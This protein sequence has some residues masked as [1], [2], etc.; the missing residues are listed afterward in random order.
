MIGE[1]RMQ[2]ETLPTYLELWDAKQREMF[3]ESISCYLHNE[4][5]ALQGNH[6]LHDVSW[7]AKVMYSRRNGAAMN[8]LDR[9]GDETKK[10]YLELAETAIICLPEL[11]DRI[12]SRYITAKA[13]IETELNRARA[14]VAAKEKRMSKIRKDS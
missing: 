7:L 1:T 4:G 2:A 12:G 5:Y 10:E 6:P 3:L 13:A 9:A 11:C 14:T 8:D